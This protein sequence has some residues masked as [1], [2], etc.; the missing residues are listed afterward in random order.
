MGSSA[1][2]T[3]HH[4]I[5]VNID[6][7]RICQVFWQNLTTMTKLLFFAYPWRHLNYFLFRNE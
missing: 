1:A 2:D 4:F 7:N 5:G 3:C 6:T